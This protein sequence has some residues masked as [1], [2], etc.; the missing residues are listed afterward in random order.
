[1][2]ILRVIVFSRN[3]DRMAFTLRNIGKMVFNGLCRFDI[4]ERGEAESARISGDVKNRRLRRAVGERR[5]CR[6]QR[7]HAELDRFEVVKRPQPVVAVSVKFERHTTDIL[8]NQ[9]DQRPGPFGGEQA[10]HIF[11]TNPVGLDCRRLARSLGII[12]VGVARRNRVD[13]VDDHVHTELF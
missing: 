10:T 7:L 2:Q 12:L 5:Y 1:M 8:L 13:D 3:A 4:D 6:M 11:K 9:R